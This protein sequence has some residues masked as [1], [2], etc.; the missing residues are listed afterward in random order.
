VKRFFLEGKE[1]LYPAQLSGGQKQ[2]TAM[3]RMLAGEPEILMLDEPFTAL[4]N[5]LKMQL[6]RELMKV[7]EDYGKTVLFVSHDRNE[8]YRMTDRIRSHGRRTAPGCAAERGAFS[9]SGLSGGNTS[10]RM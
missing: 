5:Y 1:Q 7:M 8:A 3:A 10:D 9:E 4:D 2:R 6:E